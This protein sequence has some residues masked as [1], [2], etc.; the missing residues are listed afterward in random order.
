[1]A[2]SGTQQSANLARASANVGSLQILQH[3]AQSGEPRRRHA[4]LEGLPQRFQEQALHFQRLAAL[5]INQGRGTVSAHG[6]GT[7]NSF[8]RKGIRH[9]KPQRAPSR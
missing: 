3:A 6:P 2:G 8:V 4:R 1:V 9:I 7:I 5:E